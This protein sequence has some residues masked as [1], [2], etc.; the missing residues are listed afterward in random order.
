MKNSAILTA[1][2]L[3]LLFFSVATDYLFAKEMDRLDPLSYWLTNNND[4]TF[5]RV[6]ISVTASTTNILVIIKEGKELTQ[7]I[8]DMSLGF[9]EDK[10]LD[11]TE[12]FPLVATLQIVD[13]VG[14]VLKSYTHYYDEKGEEVTAKVFVPKG[15]KLDLD[16]YVKESK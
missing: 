15:A 3:G 10:L 5:T 13:H 11:G 14:N 7:E 4:S 1:L 8:E 12:R 6:G 16:E 2:V 9:I